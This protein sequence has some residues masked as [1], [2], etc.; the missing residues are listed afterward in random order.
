MHMQTNIH[1]SVHTQTIT[2][3]EDKNAKVILL[4]FI[5]YQLENWNIF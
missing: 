1:K 4:F 3:N 2:K 5:I